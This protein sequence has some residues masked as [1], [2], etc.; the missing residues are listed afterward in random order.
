MLIVGWGGWDKSHPTSL[1]PDE[2]YTHISLWCML[3]APL[4]IGSDMSKL[5]DFTLSLPGSGGLLSGFPMMEAG[6]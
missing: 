3:A 5:D 4:L 6:C 2:Q 1:T